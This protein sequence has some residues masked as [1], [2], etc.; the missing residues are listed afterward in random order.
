M[1]I[2]YTPTYSHQE[3]LTPWSLEV[4][5]P[6]IAAPLYSALKL[7]LIIS[8]CQNSFQEG[9]MGDYTLIASNKKTTSYECSTKSRILTDIIPITKWYVYYNK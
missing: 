2:G 3:V 4:G 7:A 6:S 1:G 9:L 8:E 5:S